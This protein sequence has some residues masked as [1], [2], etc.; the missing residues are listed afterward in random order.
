M[1]LTLAVLGLLVVLTP[2][3]VRVMDRHA[4]WVLGAGYLVAT[5]LFW[6]AVDGVLHGH[7]VSSTVSWLPSLG[8]DLAFVA[9]GIGVVFTLIALIIGAFVLFYSTAYLA[10][11]GSMSFYW[12]ITTFTFAMVGLVLTD[13]LFVLF[14]CWEL[15]SLASFALIARSGSEG[16]APSFRTMLMTFIGGLF[17]LVAIGLIVALTGTTGVREAFASDA[18]AANPGLTTVI[19]VLV[20]LA[21]MSKSAQFPFHSW[22]PDAMAAATPVSA[23]LHAAAVVKAGIFLLIRFSPVFHDVAAWNGLLIVAGLLTCALGGWFALNQHDLK[24]LMAYSTVS[25][26]GL[27]VATIG[28]GTELALAAALLHV[29]A[30]ALFKSGLFMMIGV[31][32]HIAHTR[33][34][35]RF[36]A[37]MRVAPLPF[38]VT[39]VGTAS[40]AGIPPLLGFASKETVLMALGEAPG[41]AWTGPLALVAGAAASVLTFAYCAKIVFGTF[42]DGPDPR[43]P[44]G[45]GE[46]LGHTDK[47]MFTFS[48]LPILASVPLAFLLYDLEHLVVPGVK[49]ALP[50]T[51]PHPHFMLWHGFT[52]ELLASACIIAVGIVI[53]LLRRQAWEFFVRATLPFD[54]AD[55][56]NAVTRGLE[57]IGGL[58][59]RAVQP[60][61]AAP[62]LVMMLGLFAVVLLG[63]VASI[64]AGPGLPAQQADLSRPIDLVLLVLITF[65]VLATCFNRSRMGATVALS[66][67]GILVTVQIIALGAP[68]V[69]LTQLLVEAMSII[70]IML[71][72]QKLPRTFWRYPRGKQ[73]GRGI[74]A[75]LVGL[76][77]GAGAWALTGR[78]ERSE[79]AMY[80]LEE[81]YEVTGGHNIVNVILVEF[82][83]LDTLGELTVLGMAG[84]AIVAILSSI[85]DRFIDPPAGEIPDVPRKPWVVLRPAGSTAHR[86]AF[87]AWA[88][89]IPMQLTVRL[90]A[91]ILAI[92]SVLVFWRGH[93]EPGGGFIAAL[94]ASSVIGLLY[95]STS[96][97]RPVGPARLPVLLI[98]GGVLVAVASGFLGL[99]AAGSFLEPLH[100]YVGDIYVSTSMIFDVGV[101]MAVIGMILASFNLLG[102]SDN[103]FTPAGT[104]V[105]L[106]GTIYRDVEETRSH[107]GHHELTR[108]RVDEMVHGELTGPLDATR[109]ERPTEE[110]RATVKTRAR[111]G[112]QSRHLYSGVE[113]KERGE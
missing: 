41:P 79:V 51:D 85:R 5:A 38:V 25:Q 102:T 56:I 18:W 72:S 99:V 110:V 111:W 34:F 80:Y 57:R 6:P 73:L 29:I 7:P 97:D 35:R 4:G 10:H 13:D 88:N 89:M 78:R 104:D 31:V 106:E 103:A 12:L 9:D 50:G 93:N 69:T 46:G 71:V 100:G 61:R 83:A 68:D 113:P 32:D 28:V 94:I 36:P 52:V 15:T 109:G 63:G 64:L 82:R 77:A 59:A 81:T 53:I 30:H 22:L 1:P 112:R 75:V 21:A 43:S 26:L 47:V 14:L 60:V 20:A 96:T 49:A 48:A 27:I 55:V 105:L 39:I 23:Y 2:V 45:A 108:E 3:L 107:D 11:G 95:M 17:L 70:V 8:V 91:P 40:M 54:G 66:A 62:H 67:V 37:L 101:Y 98:G 33:D 87:T 92:T 90:L 58:L 76:A 24:K 65:A 44:E 84:I 42:V 19:A 16:E 74:F 86:A